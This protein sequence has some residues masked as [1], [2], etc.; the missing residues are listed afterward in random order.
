MFFGVGVE[1]SAIGW[2]SIGGSGVARGGGS[3]RRRAIALPGCRR[4]AR[5]GLDLVFDVWEHIFGA[6]FSCLS[7]P[8]NHNTPSV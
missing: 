1:I 5:W 6:D 2:H 3:G 7:S 8:T 4:A